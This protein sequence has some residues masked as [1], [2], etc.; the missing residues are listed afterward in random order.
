[1]CRFDRGV[2]FFPGSVV[3]AERLRFDFTWQG[4]SITPED[5]EKVEEHVN[6]IALKYIQVRSITD[7]PYDIAVSDLRAKTVIGE[8]YP[9]FCR[10]VQVCPSL[11]L[12]SFPL[13][14]I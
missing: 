2:V 4:G 8:K 12:S 1:M 14:I 11:F 13:F 9:Q 5:L 6:A 10:V 3:E 7:V